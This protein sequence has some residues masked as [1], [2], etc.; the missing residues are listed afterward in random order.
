METAR[1]Y[2]DLAAW[3]PLLSAPQDYAE[4]AG[5][6]RDA[7]HGARTLLELGSGG[8]NNA[9]HL[10]RWFRLTLVDL[11]PGML[12]VSRRLNPECRHVLGDMRTV[13]LNET[14]DAVFLHDAL[15]YL[16]H[17]E[18]LRAACA[19]AFVHTR[20]GGRALFV[21]DWTRGDFA[22]ATSTGGHDG[23]GRSLRYFSWVYDPDPADTT[24]LM[25][26]VYFLREG[27]AAARVVHDRHLCG[28]FP[29]QTWVR[30]IEE[31]GFRFEARPYP[32]STFPPDSARELYLGHRP[33]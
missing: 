8:G 32:H 6:F 2:S 11:A 1:L 9:S 19:T 5:I 17:E 4:E 28:L 16:L 23:G 21:A 30:A 13:R 31:A 18:D 20:P 25:D 26:M 10:K 12:D 15:S 14:F 3:W 27:S 24:I 33:G 29:R 7:L 22:P